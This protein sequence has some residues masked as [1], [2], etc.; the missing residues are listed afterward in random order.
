M[1]RSSLPLLILALA[2]PAPLLAEPA[3]EAGAAETFPLVEAGD[4]GQR[5][6][7]PELAFAH[8]TRSWLDIQRAGVQAAPLPQMS[9]PVAGRVYQRY[10]ESF[11]HPIPEYFSATAR[12]SFTTDGN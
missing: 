1:S 12:G 9:G 2:L 5:A 11:E 4:P 10:L 8:R 6:V 7:A 3:P